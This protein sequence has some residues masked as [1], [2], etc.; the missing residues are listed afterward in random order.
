MSFSRFSERDLASKPRR[1]HGHRR[2]QVLADE[3]WKQSNESE[4]S[5]SRRE[6]DGK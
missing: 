3:T 2:R 6:K 5:F 4:I 1:R